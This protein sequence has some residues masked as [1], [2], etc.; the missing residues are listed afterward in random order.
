MP[1]DSRYKIREF[2]FFTDQSKMDAWLEVE[3]AVLAAQAEAD[4]G[5]RDL[6]DAAAAIAQVE[7]VNVD[8]VKKI[9]ARTKH[10][11][12][13]FVEDVSQ[14]VDAIPEYAG[15]KLGKFV[16]QGITSYDTED[17]ALSLLLHGANMFVMDKIGRLED[18]ALEKALLYKYAP[19]NGYTHQQIAEP[20]TWG[21]RFLDFYVEVEDIRVRF[22]AEI[23]NALYAKIKGAVGVYG[24]AISPE[25]EQSVADK[26]GLKVIAAAT[27]T[28]PRVKFTNLYAPLDALAAVMEDFA[29]NLRL[30]TDGNTAEI[31]E[32]FT[33]G[34]VGSSTMTFKQN[35]IGLENITGTARMIQS[36][37]DQLRHSRPSWRERDIS[38]SI[39]DRHIFPDMLELTSYACE[40]FAKTIEKLGIFPVKSAANVIKHSGYAFAGAVKNAIKDMEGVDQQALYELVQKYSMSAKLSVEWGDGSVDF[41]KALRDAVPAEFHGKIEKATSI[42]SHLSWIDRIYDNVLGPDSEHIHPVRL[43]EHMDE[44][45]QFDLFSARDAGAFLKTYQAVCENQEAAPHRVHSP[46]PK[47]KNMILSEVGEKIMS[48]KQQR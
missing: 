4:P 16:H 1:I 11:L 13:A 37:Y 24:E 18:A 20:T 14:Q 28:I 26:L 10:D 33:A 35:P 31:K 38:G 45:G 47:R 23:E 3:K 12:R 21:K 29:Q 46:E 7:H 36:R 34:Q 2:D 22:G 5:N 27:Q 32:E 25:L 44:T 9:E 43:L 19:A 40:R 6:Q 48:A 42:A 8:N 39:E 17:T 30:A 41:I 15:R